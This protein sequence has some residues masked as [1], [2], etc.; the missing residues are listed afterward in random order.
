[1]EKPI[2]IP[3][4]YSY[5]IVGQT[6]KHLVL[7]MRKEKCGRQDFEYFLLDVETLH[8]ERVCDSKYGISRPRRYTNFP[9][10]LLSS[11]TV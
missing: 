11:P 7:E 6:E 1:M 5:D 10:A 2:S 3:F 8:M 4:G 9:P